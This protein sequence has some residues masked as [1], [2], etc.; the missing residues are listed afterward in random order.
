MVLAMADWQLKRTLEAQEALARGLEIARGVGIDGDALPPLN[1][2]WKDWI[3][4]HFLLREAKAHALMKEA[5]AL[6]EGRTR[7]LNREPEM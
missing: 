1:H 3:V 4:L 2:D 5:R 7:P 6:I